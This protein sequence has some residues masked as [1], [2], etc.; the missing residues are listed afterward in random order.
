MNSKNYDL[1]V[2]YRIYPG[3]SK[4]PPVHSDSK[5]KLSELCLKSFKDSLGSLKIKMW[6]LLDN[7]PPD[8]ETL[9]RKYFDDEDL[10]MINLP[11]IGNNG[12]FRKQ[13]ELLLEQTDSEYVYFAE[14]DYFYLPG[15]FEEMYHFARETG[16]DCVTP[17]DHKDLYTM[18]LHRYRSRITAWGTRH[19]R[20]VSASCMT[21]LTTKKLLSKTKNIFLSY[22]RRNDDASMWMSMTKMKVFNPA[23]YLKYLFKDRR[24]FKVLLKIWFFGWRQVFFHRKVV[25]WS[26]MPAVATHME[27]NFLS[28]GRDWNE[29]F[30]NSL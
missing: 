2:A 3:V 24:M 25:L 12:T 20:D 15:A 8:Y 23:L 17:Y 13:T 9:F 5:L 18:D 11:G 19:W 21:F 28:P 26:P 16:A 7:C 1:A 10:V 4:L 27:S 30:K 14:D 6:V 22:S 29:L